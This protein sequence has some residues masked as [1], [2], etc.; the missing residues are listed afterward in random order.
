M[1]T[2]TSYDNYYFILNLNI[3]YKYTNKKLNI[4]NRY[5]FVLHYI[6]Y[7]GHGATTV[8]RPWISL[9]KYNFIN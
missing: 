1:G 9:Y 7:T 2:I 6:I 8:Q 3:K 5:I 4:Y